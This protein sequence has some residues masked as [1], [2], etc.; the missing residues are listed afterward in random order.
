LRQVAAS[1]TKQHGELGFR[2]LQILEH[3]R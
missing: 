3:L 1:T 2:L